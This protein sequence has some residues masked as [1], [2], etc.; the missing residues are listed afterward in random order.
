MNTFSK[1]LE[2]CLRIPVAGWLFGS[3]IKESVYY[4]MRYNSIS[5][6]IAYKNREYRTAVVEVVSKIRD[7]IHSY[8]H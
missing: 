4:W 2:T 5:N 6:S 7:Q 1:T 3:V 8:L